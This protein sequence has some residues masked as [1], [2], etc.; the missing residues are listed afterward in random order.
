MKKWIIALGFLLILSGTSYS[1]TVAQDCGCGLGKVLIGEKQGLAW[2]L[3]GTFLNGI[4]GNQTFGMTTG[5]L[6]CGGT[7]NLVENSHFD[8]F[9]ADNMDHLAVDIA[10]GGGESL[11]ALVEIAGVAPMLRSSL[12]AEL[13]GHF[14]AIY[15]DAQVTHTHV[16]NT[17]REIMAGI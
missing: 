17:I 9:V 13:Q 15:P 3:L 7:Q 5:T 1:A 14:D 10:S 6:E 11:D 12:S 16:S 8:I 2:N 4:S